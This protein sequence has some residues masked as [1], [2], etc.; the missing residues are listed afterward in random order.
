MKNK[1]IHEH[2]Y[3]KRTPD[4]NRI[5]L[6]HVLRESKSIMIELRV[7]VIKTKITMEIKLVRAIRVI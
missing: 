6:I 5:S 1:N 3:Q 7:N 2:S 4:V